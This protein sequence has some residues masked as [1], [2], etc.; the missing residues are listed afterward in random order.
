L[1]GNIIPACRQ[2]GQKKGIISRV[3]KYFNSYIELLTKP[4]GHKLLMLLLAIFSMQSVTSISHIPCLPA[5]RYKWFLAP[6]SKLSQ[7]SYYYLLSYT[8]LPL[9]KF[10]EVTL[11][12]AIDLVDAKLSKLPI[13]L[14]LDDTLQAKFGTKFACPPVPACRP[15]CRQTGG[16][17]TRP[18]LITQS[19]AAHPT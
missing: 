7:N 9:E 11:R 5:G 18:C 2:A 8:D 10:A 15:A 16:S 12:K 13:L 4:T 14:L 6:L 1:Y 17:V 3:K 19:T